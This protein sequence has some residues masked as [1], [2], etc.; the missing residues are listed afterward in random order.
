MSDTPYYVIDDKHGGCLTLGGD[1]S[2]QA[3]QVFLHELQE[4]FGAQYSKHL[5]WGE[6]PES[7]KEKGYW[8]VEMFG[9]RFFVMRDRDHGLWLSSPRPPADMSGFLRVARHFGAREQMS[10]GKRIAR[11]LHLTRRGT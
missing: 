1:G 8:T 10:L 2:Y 11:W 9:Q 6:C 7:D 3:C 4:V 5:E